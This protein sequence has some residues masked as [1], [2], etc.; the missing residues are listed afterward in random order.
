MDSPKRTANIIMGTNGTMGTVDSSPTSPFAH[1][2]WN[3]ATVAPYA[4]AT[5]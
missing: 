2:H 3:T 1:P 5:D 4:A